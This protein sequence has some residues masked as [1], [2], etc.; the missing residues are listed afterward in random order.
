MGKANRIKTQKAAK[1]LASPLNKSP[2]G[3]NTKGGMP[4][5]VGTLIVV[6]VLLALVLTIV[7]S[8]MSSRGVFLRMRVIA[9]SE[10]YKIT[11]PM[12]SYM[13]YTECYNMI[14]TY[15]QLAAQFG[16]SSL[17]VPGGE[18]GDNLN[19]SLSLRSQI[20][21]DYTDKETGESYYMTWFDF[22]AGKATESVKQILACCEAA[23]A[24][25]IE[26]GDAEYAEIDA[27]IESLKRSA[28]NSGV[29]TYTYLC[30]V[31]GEGVNEK[32]VRNMM[33]LTMLAAKYN[34]IRYDELLVPLDSNRI[35]DQY[36]DNKDK[37]DIYMDFLTFSFTASFTPS[38]KTNADEKKAENEKLA[39]EYEAKKDKY[40]Q[41]VK[42][43]EACTTKEAFL[44]K[45]DV[46]LQEYYLEQEV[47]AAK[48][49][50]RAKLL[51]DAKTEAEKEEIRN[52]DIVLTEKQM[53]E[54]RDA[55]QES[56]LKAVKNALK[57]NTSV[58]TISDTKVTD[59]LKDSTTPRK[60]GDRKT[61]VK[62]FD[63]F[64]ND[65]TTTSGNKATT[66]TKTSSSYAV[67]FTLSGLH[68]NDGLVRSVAHILFKTDT[69]KNVT[70]I[71]KLNENAQELA[72]RILDRGAKIS[73]EEM[74]K[75][76]IILMK[77]EGKLT[78][79][80]V[81]GKTY[82][83]IDE[84]V[85]NTYGLLYTEDSNVFYDNVTE[86]QMVEEFNDWLFAE[87]R[88]EGEVSEDGGVETSF[89]YHVM[90]YRG[91]QKPA[92][93][94][95]IQTELQSDDHTEWLEE[96]VEEYPTTFKDKES[97]WNKISG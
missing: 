85:F 46:I 40:E 6:V 92:W 33:E 67:Y 60:E 23:R 95:A 21:C 66:Y 80:T 36:E 84:D 38:E 25:G 58:E 4:T 71:T 10:H 13:I 9:R 17:A 37:Y 35:D 79:K 27:T 87:G 15:D 65:D 89:G 69:Y 5:W 8:V 16:I 81:E 83:E 72:Q 96:T 93:R 30:S 44:A 75:E 86:G 12:M 53:Q 55:A 73:A 97:Y 24:K 2:K 74:A 56:R 94:Y 26:L 41:Y 62:S 68:R 34:Q 49:A 91:D 1:T 54:C 78:Q 20:Y 3:R 14:D 43:L 82:W 77:E 19:T 70:D 48:E 22:F 61:F 51:K 31:Y 11:V 76:L 59:W 47:E 39:A 29:S 52:K 50:E 28:E 32:T 90:L 64:G 63:A 45:L 57:K 18:G 88:I 7:L 42:D